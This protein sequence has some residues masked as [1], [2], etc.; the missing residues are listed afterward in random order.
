MSSFKNF[1]AAQSGQGN[2]KPTDTTKNAPATVEPVAQP[3]SAPAQVKDA[4]KA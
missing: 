3:D 4:P 1:S 2:D